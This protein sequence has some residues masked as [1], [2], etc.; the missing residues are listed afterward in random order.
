MTEQ[1]SRHDR[2]YANVSR[3]LDTLLSASEGHADHAPHV[4]R[5]AGKPANLIDWRTATYYVA[6]TRELRWTCECRLTVYYLMT[7]G[8]LAWIRR[9]QRPSALNHRARITETDH[10]RYPDAERLW[11]RVLL[12]HAR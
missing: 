11:E 2:A 8:G 7:G 3:R 5:P 10:M 9:A 6:R 1:L 4:Q 12:G